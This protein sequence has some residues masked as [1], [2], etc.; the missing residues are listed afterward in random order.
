MEPLA[1]TVPQAN[2]VGST[3]YFIFFRCDL[4]TVWLQAEL[5]SLINGMMGNFNVSDW[6]MCNFQILYTMS[7]ILD[8]TM[9]SDAR[10]IVGTHN[11]NIKEATIQ[12]YTGQSLATTGYF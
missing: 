9:V 6:Q 7:H 2:V 5:D 12:P 1:A 3:D 10:Y 11:I 4:D 8:S